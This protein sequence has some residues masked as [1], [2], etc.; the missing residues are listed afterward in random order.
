L[1][2]LSPI[3]KWKTARDFD[4]LSEH[5][6]RTVESHV[7]GTS[8][9]VSQPIEDRTNEMISGSRADV[10]IQLFGPDLDA[11]SR[12]AES[13][14]SV[15]RGI[16]GTGDIRIE[17][18]LGAP[19]I[20]AS[21]DRA[22]MARHGVR[23]EDAFQVL[24]AAREGLNV[25]ELFEDERRIGLR[26]VMPPFAPTAEAIGGLPVRTSEGTTV[27]LRE[28]LTLTELDGPTAIRR[29]ARSRAV[30]VDVNLRGRDLVSWVDEARRAVAAKV[31]LP[32]GYS[33]KWGGQFENFERA[34]KRL[35]I[36][37]PVVVAII[38]GMLLW[39]FQNLR[40]A[41]AV[42]LLVPLSL[43]GGMLG[44]LL[45]GLSFSLPAAVGF[46][47]LGGIGVLNGVVV[48]NEVRRRLDEGEPMERAI[49]DSMVHM[50]RAVLTT[51]TVAA[52][53][54]LPMA[55]ATSAGAEV[56]RPLA[57]VVVVGMAVGVYLTLFVLPGVLRI[58]LG[59]YGSED[60]AAEATNEA[61]PELA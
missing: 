19:V 59:S 43:G 56:Q 52:L 12:T 23:T 55:I 58:L 4:T 60:D 9:S 15:V 30:R 7:P 28:V 40:L 45:S 3:G 34:T 50:L 47:A 44:L 51:T 35:S 27:P 41:T 42:F 1:T 13:I 10:Q 11:L 37:V 6:K 22:R 21:A 57:R 32:S 18:I 5:I 25:G 61:P 49:C 8:V 29:E 24:Q 17:R 2:R 54:F 31:S 53:G 26:V 20:N 48:A 14:G 38:F 33:V 16:P 46:I 39:M 36:V